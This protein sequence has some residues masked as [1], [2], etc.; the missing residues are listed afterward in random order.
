LGILKLIDLNG[1]IITIDVIGTQVAIAEQI[2]DGNG[3]Y[4]LALKANQ[5]GL[6]QQIMNCVEEN[7]RDDFACSR[8]YG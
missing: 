6:F 7:I 2:I 1:S 5:D 8:I 3:H 4:I